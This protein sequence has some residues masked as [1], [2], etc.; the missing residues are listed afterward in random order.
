[1]LARWLGVTA[2]TVRELAKAGVA[3][4]AGRGQYRLEES[5]RRYCKHV[6]R[7]ASQ[8]GGEASLAALRDERIR[9]AKEQADALALK[10]AEARGG[11]LEAKAVEAEWSNILR[12]VRAGMLAA[13]SRA[14]SRLPHLSPHDIAEIDAEVRAVLL[15]VGGQ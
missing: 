15:E 9:I 1:V 5:V 4:R 14:G 11:L 3:V 10:N 13:P 12:T 2:K 8:G 6:R 7:T